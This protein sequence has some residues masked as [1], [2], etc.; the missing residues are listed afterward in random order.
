MGPEILSGLGKQSAERKSE[1]P[2][3]MM[4][5]FKAATSSAAQSIFYAKFVFDLIDTEF[6]PAAL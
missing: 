4:A 1:T 2:A 6:Q 3:L 5:G